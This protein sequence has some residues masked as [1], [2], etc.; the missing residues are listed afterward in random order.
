MF[1]WVHYLIISSLLFSLYGTSKSFFAVILSSS[2]LYFLFCYT[3]S[4]FL[5]ITFGV[6]SKPSIKMLILATIFIISKCSNSEHS[7]YYSILL[8]HSYNL[9]L[10]L[11]LKFSSAL[12]IISIFFKF[13]FSFLFLL[14]SLVFHF[15][16][17]LLM[18][19]KLPIHI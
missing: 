15:R 10:S 13:L 16:G 3:L 18:S 14:F 9:F 2:F 1:Y 5:E 12:C 19:D 4:Y 17:F 8:F 11:I 7:L 6:S